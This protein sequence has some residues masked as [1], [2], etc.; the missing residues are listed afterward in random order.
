MNAHIQNILVVNGD[1]DSRSGLSAL[2]LQE[3]RG[4][5]LGRYEP[6]TKQ[7]YIPAA[8]FKDFCVKSQTH[9]TG[10]LRQLAAMGIY[11]GTINKRISKGMKVVTPVVRALHFDVTNVDSLHFDLPENDNREPDVQP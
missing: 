2:P 1:V 9:Y 3:P 4:E 11:K 5:L 6:D 10:L 8:Q 7:V